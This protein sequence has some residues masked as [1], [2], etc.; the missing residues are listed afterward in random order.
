MPDPIY[1]VHCV[2]PGYRAHLVRL[3]LLDA[4][5]CRLGLTTVRPQGRTPD[6]GEGLVPSGE[7]LRTLGRRMLLG[8]GR[9][10]LG[11][12]AACHSRA[13]EAWLVSEPDEYC[14][15]VLAWAVEADIPVAR[16]DPKTQ[17]QAILLGEVGEARPAPSA[18]RERPAFRSAEDLAE[19]YWRGA[20]GVLGARALPI[21]QVRVQSGTTSAAAMRDRLDEVGLRIAV[22]A[23]IVEGCRQGWTPRQWTVFELR[24]RFEMEFGDIAS[25]AGYADASGACRCWQGV[26]ADLRRAMRERA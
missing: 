26:L 5:L 8:D 4:G 24:G 22:A 3:R 14:A 12:G 11:A 13:R 21:D 18:G 23:A 16:I 25:G 15:D 2:S 9:E 7:S 17:A 6:D 1:L 20:E 10:H 19:C